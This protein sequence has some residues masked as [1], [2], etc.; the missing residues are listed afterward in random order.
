MAIYSELG[1]GCSSQSTGCT[2]SSGCPSDRAADF[3]IK[4]NDTTPPFKIAVEDCD[5]VVDL[6][7]NFILEVNIWIKTKLKKSITNS[8]TEIY[9]ADNIGFNQVVENNVI[10]MDR[11][12]N[13]EKM[14]ITGFD[15][16]NYKITVTRGFDGTEAQAWPKGSSLRVFRAMDAEGE[17]ESVFEDVTQEDGTVLKDQLAN[18]FLT[19]NWLENTTSLSGCFW[20]EFKLSELSEDLQETLSVK[21]FPSEGEAFLIR[22]ID[23]PT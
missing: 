15:E 22:I 13:P 8:D 21:R 4:R 23:S 6:T 18:T 3:C 17:I 2:D 16:E 14:L 7:G 10:V 11:A 1:V 20:L 9:F 19:F 5:G 12:R